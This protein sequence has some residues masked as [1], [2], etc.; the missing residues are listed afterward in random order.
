MFHDSM[1]D[2][3]IVI[4]EALET[5]EQAFGVVSNVPSTWAEGADNVVP[6]IMP[7]HSPKQ[8]AFLLTLFANQGWSTIGEGL[9]ALGVR[10]PVQ[11][12]NRLTTAQKNERRAQLADAVDMNK[13]IPLSANTQNWVVGLIRE[14]SSSDNDALVAAAAKGTEKLSDFDVSEH[15][16][17]AVAHAI[18]RIATMLGVELPS[19]RRSTTDEAPAPKRTRAAAKA[20]TASDEEVI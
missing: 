2:G 1:N 9:E 15:D 3:T 16:G 10:T 6:R 7:N 20:K 14:A 5:L 18:T 19:M 8:N 12:F 17:Q 11:A 4:S 13:S